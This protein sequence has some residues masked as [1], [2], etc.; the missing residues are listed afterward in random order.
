MKKPSIK[1]LDDLWSYAV[2]TRAGFRSEHSGKADRLNSHHV[3]GKAGHALR[4]DL[5]NGVC[6]TAGE[7]KFIAH[8]AG[9]SAEFRR[10]AIKQRGID[11]E[12]LLLKRKRSVQIDR[13]YV[14]EYIKKFI[15]SIEKKEIIYGKRQRVK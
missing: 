14:Y 1:T 9:R 12:Y 13:W 8:H 4:W 15:K 5:D 2:K 10:W 3:D 11:E 6:I 7:H